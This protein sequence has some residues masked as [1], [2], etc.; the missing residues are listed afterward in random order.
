[1]KDISLIQPKLSLSQIANELDI[2]I[3]AVHKKL[4]GADV[5]YY[6]Y[7]NKA[8]ITYNES[9]LL[10]HKKLIKKPYIINSHIVKGGT[11]KTTSV[12]NIG[13][14][15]NSYGLKVLYIDNDPQANLTDSFKID[16]ED[17]PVLIDCIKDNYD[18]KEC[19]VNI[20]DGMDLMP[21]R[22]ENVIIDSELHT[23]KIPLDRIF[24]TFFENT[25]IEND[26]DL[27]LIDC[28]PTM[29]HIVTAANLFA[30]LTVIPLNPNKFSVKGL[31]ILKE[32]SKNLKRFYN[33]DLKYKVFLNKFDGN[34]IL[35]DKIINT[36]MTDEY[37][38]ENALSTAVRRSQEVENI[39]DSGLT[40]FSHLRKSEAREDYRRLTQEL[41]DL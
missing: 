10:F 12:L 21:S 13:A 26:Y 22:I 31:K 1:M 34:T 4:K 41:I 6:K 8:Y 32:E 33:I 29:G 15:A 39:I 19:I 35:S 25:I 23:K 5:P 40:L 18:V 16:A 11:G 17:R 30:D 38:D 14:C 3:Q 27:I 24:N 9:K 7:G 20:C 36:V 28:P 2:T 37:K